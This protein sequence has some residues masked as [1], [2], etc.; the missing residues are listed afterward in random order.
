MLSCEEAREAVERLRAMGREGL[1]QHPCI[2]PER[3][4][5]VL[6]GCAI[7]AAIHRLWPAPQVVV[8]DRGLREGMLLRMMRA[9]RP[10]HAAPAPASPPARERGCKPDAEAGLARARRWRCRLRTAGRRHRGQ[11]W[12]ERQLNDPYVAAAKAQGYRSR[13]AFKLIELDDKFQLIRPRLPRARPRRRAR[14]VEPGGGAARG[15]AGGGARPAADRPGAGGG[16]PAGR[17]RRPGDAGAAAG[18]AGRA[19]RPGA[20]RHGAEHHGPRRDRPYPH[21]RARRNGVRFAL[22]VL[23]PGGAF[24]TKVFQGGSER[25]LLAPMKRAFASVRHAK[26]PASRKG[27]SELY[28][29]AT[30]FR[31]T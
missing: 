27:S 25:D 4:D 5:F 30:G 26:P 23:A 28:V 1:A 9:E 11:K 2:G 3:A 17:F 24:V 6:P 20:V 29:V 21:R 14:R 13:A 15:G 7:F 8:A 12:L 19:G 16:F 22:Q 31:P 10:R 18:V